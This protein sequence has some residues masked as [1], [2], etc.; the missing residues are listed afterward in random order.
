MT[1]C[2]RDP[3]A[4][5]EEHALRVAD[6]ARTVAYAQR[7][8]GARSPEFRDATDALV[9]ALIDARHDMGPGSRAALASVSVAA[10]EARARLASPGP[11]RVG[12][13]AAEGK[14][15]VPY[16][17]SL[18]GPN[19]ERCLLTMNT[20]FPHDDDRAFIAH[21]RDDV[22]FLAQLARLAVGDPDAR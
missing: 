13:V 5:A 16:A 10:C 15:W 3:G 6:R 12:S 18:E 17:G 20:H 7:V 11:W 2:D 21:A 8:F 19:G 14:V 9:R 1:P 4:I 22:P